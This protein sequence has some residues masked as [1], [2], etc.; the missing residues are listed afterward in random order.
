MEEAPPV[1]CTQRTSADAGVTRIETAPDNGDGSFALMTSA[2]GNRAKLEPQRQETS[3]KQTYPEDVFRGFDPKR[4]TSDGETIKFPDPDSSIYA[5]NNK[6]GALAEE[7]DQ[8][9]QQTETEAETVATATAPNENLSNASKPKDIA[10]R[11]VDPQ[12]EAAK[13]AAALTRSR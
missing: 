9:M 7:T 12:V 8:K 13:A 1:Q 6:V 4:A 10:P 5:G 11:K 3:P 2:I